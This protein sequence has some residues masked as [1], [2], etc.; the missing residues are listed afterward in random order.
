MIALILTVICSSSI[1]LILK[2]NH[3]REGNPLLL[4]AGNY[5]IAALISLGFVLADKKAMF[6]TET[7]IFGT[8]LASLFVITFFAFAKAVGAAGTA[9]ATVSSRLS[10]IVPL[11]L[12]IM[13][14]HEEPTVYQLTG[15]ILT[16]ITIILFYFSLRNESSTKLRFIDYFYLLAV[17]IGIGFND[18]CMK[19]FQQWRPE[20]EKSYFIFI[21]FITATMY[22]FSAILIKRIRFNKM[23]LIRGGLLGVPNMFST[24]FILLALTQIPA[25]VVYPV[26]NIGI[27]LLTALGAA[28]IWKEK[29]NIYGKWAL[30]SGIIAI[31]FLGIG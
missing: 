24:F 31:I 3:M 23:V 16:F 27:I 4:L 1:A 21:I 8:L 28:I 10:V 13:I 19:V 9:L 22:T 7:F 12:S 6:S 26:T 14:Y 15:I 30:L 20:S 2:D 17:L 18:F 25:I 5:F 11:L 29:L